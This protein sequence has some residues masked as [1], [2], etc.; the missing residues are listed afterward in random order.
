ME[1]PHCNYFTGYNFETH[2]T[3]DGKNGDFY[4]LSNDIALER[5]CGFMETESKDL[6]ACPDCGKLFIEA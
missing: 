2:K 1:C 3:I 5:S 4:T 6:Y